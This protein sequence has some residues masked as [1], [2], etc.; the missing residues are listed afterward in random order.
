MLI[1]FLQSLFVVSYEG[2]ERLVDIFKRKSFRRNY[3]I[4]KL[5]FQRPSRA[6]MKKLDVSTDN[7]KSTRKFTCMFELLPK[8]RVFVTDYVYLYTP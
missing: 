8:K 6:P 2:N 3:V 1:Y 4:Q 7:F 5:Q